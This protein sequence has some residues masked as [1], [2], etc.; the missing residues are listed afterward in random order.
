MRRAITILGVCGLLL[1]GLNAQTA[2]EVAVKTDLNGE[3][4]S[5]V[6]VPGGSHWNPGIWG[7]R[8]R[9]GM[10]RSAAVLNPT[11]DQRGDLLPS[12]AESNLAPHHP[13]AVWSRFNGRDY[14]LVWSTWA[15]RWTRI[16]PIVPGR[17]AGDD[18]NPEIAFTA[19]GRAVVTWWNRDSEGNGTVFFSTYLNRRWMQPAAISSEELGGRYPSIGLNQDGQIEITY[20][21][22]DGRM[23]FTQ[24]VT[25]TKPNTI[26]D[27]IDPQSFIFLLTGTSVSKSSYDK[28]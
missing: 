14:D 1:A 5:T 21:S 9:A 3:Y 4:V 24:R 22:D 2:A 10:H 11:G 13:M 25:M 28:Y 15:H 19:N 17:P 7:G 20:Q 23:E 6:I 26:T 8:A 18:L 16:A 27:D 12:I